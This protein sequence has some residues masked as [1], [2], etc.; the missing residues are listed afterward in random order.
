M[1]QVLGKPASINVRK[2][3]WTCAELG[4]PHEL[5]RLRRGFPID[6]FATGTRFTLAD[7]VLGLSLNRWSMTPM[8]RPALPA[9]VAYHE[10]LLARPGYR[11]HGANDTP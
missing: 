2:V 1:L 6:P 4:L 11:S 5:Q 9:L 3:L 10:R 8:T 7:V